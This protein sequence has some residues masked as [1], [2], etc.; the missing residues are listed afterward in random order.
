MP[1]QTFQ[2]EH[3]INREL[4]WLEFN[5]RVGGGRR[6]DEPAVERVIPVDLLR[7]PRRV[8]HGPGG[9]LREQAFGNG[10]R[11]TTRPTARAD[12]A[13]QRICARTQEMV[14]AQYRCWNESVLP[15]LR[16]KA[17]DLRYEELNGEQRAS[18]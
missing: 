15:H 3:F 18:C 4:S 7:E 14:A 2:P 10:V 9:G 1:E 6:H 8:L 17:C 12:H 5:A 13:M 16:R 11:R